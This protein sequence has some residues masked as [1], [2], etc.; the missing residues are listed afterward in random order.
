MNIRVCSAVY[1]Y[2]LFDIKSYCKKM[3]FSS[4]TQYFF[5]YIA[6]YSCHF[7]KIRFFHLKQD[8]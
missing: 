6:V 1:Y 5:I 7:D 2:H 4:C 8:S 3:K